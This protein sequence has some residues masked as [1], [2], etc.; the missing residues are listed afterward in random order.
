VATIGL[1]ISS[2]VG[3]PLAGSAAAITHF[4]DVE[5]IGGPQ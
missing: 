1:G 5:T 3:G 4:V 2:T